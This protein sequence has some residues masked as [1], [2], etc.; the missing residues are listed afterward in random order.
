MRRLLYLRICQLVSTFKPIEGVD[1]IFSSGI[2]GDQKDTI[3][4]FVESVGATGKSMEDSSFP[5]QL[6]KI[7]YHAM[8]RFVSN[9]NCLSYAPHD[10]LIEHFRHFVTLL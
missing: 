2:L 4:G 6:E 10:I 5:I 9:L 8:E 3:A 1:D 7:S